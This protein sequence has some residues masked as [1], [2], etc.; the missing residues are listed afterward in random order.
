MRFTKLLMSSAVLAAFSCAQAQAAGPTLSD[1][2][3]NSGI[4]I[5][6]AM[7]ASYDFASNDAVNQVFNTE[8]DAFVFHQANLSATKAFDNGIGAGLNVI[9]GKD[10]NIVSGDLLDG[11][12]FDVTQAYISK[13]T[14]NLTLVGGRFV[15][16]AGMEVINPAGNLNATRS[17]LFGAQPLVHEGVRATYKVSDAF[18]VT[19]GL[20]NAQFAS[21][22]GP[23]FAGLAGIGCTQATLAAVGQRDNNTDTTVEVQFAFTPTKA[24]SVF[25]TGY[26]GNED[27]GDGGGLGNSA[28]LRADTVDLVVNFAVSDALYLGLNADYFNVEGD[29]GLGGSVEAKGVAGYVQAKLLPKVRVALRSE[30]LTRDNDAPGDNE[31]IITENT[32][33]VGYAVSD[34]LEMLVEGRHD[35]ARG[36]SAGGGDEDF[37]PIDGGAEDDQYTGTIKAI[38]KF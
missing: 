12:D 14:G 26:T 37:A 4:T 29:E 1:V 31:S 9:L 35:R 21:S 3:G 25:L 17:L 28:N 8:N 6:G 32:L 10:A 24:L 36:D 7:D 15:T 23:S 33:T 13:S 22:C 20:N 11:D 27:S 18:G 2:L 19:L 16:L 5:G 30:F 34:N 38:L